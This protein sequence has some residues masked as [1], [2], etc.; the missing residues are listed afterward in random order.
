MRIILKTVFFFCCFQ[1]YGQYIEKYNDYSIEWT[2]QYRF[3]GKIQ[4]F[5]DL[6]SFKHSVLV[7]KT[8]FGGFSKRNSSL[9]IKNYNNLQKT[10]EGE[11]N[12]KSEDGKKVSLLGV[13][14]IGKSNIA[15]SARRSIWKRQHKIYYH[16]FN[17]H[18]IDGVNYGEPLVSYISPYGFNFRGQL[19]YTTSENDK[20]G[21]VYFTIPTRADDYV[22]IGYKLINNENKTLESDLYLLPYKHY[23]VEINGQYLS[24]DGDYFLV[25]SIFNKRT[26][27]NQWTKNNRKYGKTEIITFKDDKLVQ[28]P[29]EDVNFV[30]RSI[31]LDTDDDGYLVGTGFYTDALGGNVR[32]TYFFKFDTEK[33][34]VV[35]LKKHQLTNDIVSQNIH[36]R[37]RGIFS[38]MFRNRSNDNNFNKFRITFFEPTEDGGYIALAEHIFKEFRNTDNTNTD[39]PSSRIDEYFY[40]NDLV[41]YKIKPNGELDWVNRIQ[42]V[43]QSMNDEGYYLSTAQFL[44]NSKLHIFFNDN[45]RNYDIDGK[46]ID[47]EYVYVSTV[48]RRNNVIGA[49]SLNIKNG[50]KT[51]KKLAGR[52]TN[53]VV[54]VP[55]LSRERKEEKELLIYGNRGNRHKYGKL[56]FF[57]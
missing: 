31:A 55:R 46:F 52:K 30:I 18:Q 45:R 48:S 41:V 2:D 10:D 47:R 28:L 11:I 40:N 34:K 51:R 42:K 24:D 17:H 23:E 27:S 54:L 33:E 36:H 35:L 50:S 9:R 13:L 44:T 29:I 15:F 32:G 26:I 39:N 57:I 7:N 4:G 49:V 20:Y 22:S 38:Q 14:D 25:A 21:A 53:G 56:R 19:D 43:Q 1:I 5:F 8:G 3:R 6:T 16:K 12:L 37:K